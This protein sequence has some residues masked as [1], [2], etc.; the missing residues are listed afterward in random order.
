MKI[1]LSRIELREYLSQFKERKRAFVPTMGALHKGHISLV[2][3]AVEIGDLTIVSIFVNPTQFNDP[4]DLDK[5]PRTPEKDIDMLSEVL[6]EDDV[7][8]LPGVDDVY[9]GEVVPDVRLMGLDLVMEG[10]H[11]PGHFNGVVRVVKLLFDSVEPDIALFGQKDFQQL[12]IIRAMTLQTNPSISI[13]SCPILREPN[14]LAMSSRNVRLSQETREN[15]S[16][17]YRTLK[18]HSVL[19]P[20]N[21]IESIANSV[22]NDIEASGEFKVEY[23]EIVDHKSLRSLKSVSDIDPGLEYYGCIAVNTEGIRLIDN[24]HFSFPVSKG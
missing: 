19:T 8:Y 7:I 2:E 13:I 21:S 22:I 10:K 6:R 11:R 3:Q 18:K 9:G 4:A 23:F 14:G 16:I 12:T 1:I 24:M 15:A 17:I 20:E 5:Y